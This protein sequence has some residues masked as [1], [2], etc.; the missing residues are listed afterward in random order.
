MGQEIPAP[1][2]EVIYQDPAYLKRA[3]MKKLAIILGLVILAV[4]LLLSG[5]FA[6]KHYMLKEPATSISLPQ[7]TPSQPKPTLVPLPT[8]ETGPKTLELKDCNINPLLNPLVDRVI[9]VS[10]DTPAIIILLGNVNEITFNKDSKTADISLL[11]FKAEQIYS[12]RLTQ[13]NGLV[14]NQGLAKEVSVSDL[15]TG[16]L[17][18]IQYNCYPQ[19]PED[20]R[21]KLAQVYIRP[22]Q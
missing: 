19:N 4:I 7:P 21:F 13:Q 6:V 1:T 15:K 9:P 2:P 10:K 3:R 8:Q 11:S 17:L 16:Q 20:Q 22:V 5:Y 12:L 18:E 14:F